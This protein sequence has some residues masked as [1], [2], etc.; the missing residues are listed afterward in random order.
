MYLHVHVAYIFILINTAEE[1]DWQYLHVKSHAFM[2]WYI[3]YNF[4][5]MLFSV[6]MYVYAH[7]CKV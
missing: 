6:L 7:K 1:S 3:L 4:C 5:K 2:Y